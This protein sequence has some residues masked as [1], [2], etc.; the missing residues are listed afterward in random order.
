MK[1]TQQTNLFTVFQKHHKIILYSQNNQNFYPLH[2]FHIIQS[3]QLLQL[4]L[5]PLYMLITTRDILKYIHV[6]HEIRIRIPRRGT[7]WSY[8]LRDKWQICVA[9]HNWRN[10]CLLIRG[11]FWLLPASVHWDASSIFRSW[12]SVLVEVVRSRSSAIK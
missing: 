12:W 11:V 9:K 10:T 2:I 3:D 5:Y 8:W 6:L 4:G 1:C 7:S